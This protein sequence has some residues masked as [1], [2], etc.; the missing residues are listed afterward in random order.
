MYKKH[1][2]IE[3]S[4]GGGEARNFN[5]AAGGPCASSA[6][7]H[8]AKIFCGNPTLQSLVKKF[9]CDKP[10]CGVTTT[11]PLAAHEPVAGI[12][13]EKISHRS[14]CLESS[15]GPGRLTVRSTWL[16]CRRPESDQPADGW[17]AQHRSSVHDPPRHLAHGSCRAS[18]KEPSGD[19]RRR[20]VITRNRSKTNRTIAISLQ[21]VAWGK[22]GHN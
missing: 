2:S 21:S 13:N 3:L 4:C 6:A 9:A 10:D 7:C 12:F 15:P 18:A 20:P 8:I 1:S 17:P 16:C 5:I 19:D 11:F 22:S 14:R